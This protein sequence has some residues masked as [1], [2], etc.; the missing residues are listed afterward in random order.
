MNKAC[1]N[2]LPDLSKTSKETSEKEPGDNT[3]SRLF[4]FTILSIFPE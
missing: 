4:N 1:Q 3:I 2:A